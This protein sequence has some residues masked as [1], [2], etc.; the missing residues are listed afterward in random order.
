MSNPP[1]EKCDKYKK[2]KLQLQ[3]MKTYYKL[4]CIIRQSGSRAFSVE[5]SE[6]VPELLS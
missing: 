1:V 3:Y 2:R 4:Q 6:T 5:C